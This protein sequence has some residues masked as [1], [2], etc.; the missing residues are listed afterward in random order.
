[1]MTGRER[2][3][4]V[5]QRRRPDHPPVSCWYHFS[6]DQQSGPAAVEAHLRHLDKYDLDFLKVMNDLPFPRGEVNAV[7]TTADLRKIK[8][9]DGDHGNLSEQITLIRELARRVGKD[10]LIPTTL[11]NPWAILR[12]MTRP[13][14]HEHGT[15]K[16]DGQDD[17]D[18]TISK[19]LAEDRAA[20]RSALEALARTLAAFARAALDAGASGLYMSVRDD[21][22]NTPANGPETYDELVRPA[23]LIILEA[24]KTAPLNILHVCGRPQNLPRFSDYPVHVL[25]WADRAAGPSIAYARDRVKPTIAGGVDNLKTLPKGTPAD[26]ASEVADA[27]RQAKDRPIIIAPGCTF[28]PRAVPEENLRAM[29][30]AARKGYA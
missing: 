5:L 3:E 20:V 13:P 26:V 30:D 23:D 25:H 21:W 6:H 27:L 24:A 29:V 28:D 19:L 22:V 4:T 2:I 16:L 17:R 7:N 12:Q 10:V 15:P 11:F 18:E 9:L 1:M 8:P 14:S